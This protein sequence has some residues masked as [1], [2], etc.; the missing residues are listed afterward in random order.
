MR[1]YDLIGKKKRGGELTDEEIDISE[2]TEEPEESLES[3][4]SDH[5]E[6]D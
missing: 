2:G 1:M 4:E 6:E 3:E 5:S